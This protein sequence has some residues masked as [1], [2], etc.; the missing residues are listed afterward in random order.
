[1]WFVYHQ[2]LQKESAQK[3]GIVYI[4]INRQV[5]DKNVKRSTLRL[6]MD[7]CISIKCC[8]L[9]LCTSSLLLRILVPSIKFFSS[10]RLRRRIE[11]HTSIKT[12]TIIN[13]M[14]KFGLRSENLPTSI[15][16]TYNKK[17]SWINECELIVSENNRCRRKKNERYHTR[18][19]ES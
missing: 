9:H 3:D 7:H 18:R 8:C 6:M 1:M 15:G 16:G 2:A 10:K 17:P 12:P 19:F 4:G 11:I 5:G 14:K 13:D